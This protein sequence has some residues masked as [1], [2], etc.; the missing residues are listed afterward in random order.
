MRG[1]Y[2]NL[3]GLFQIFV[4]N[5]I[6]KSTSNIHIYKYGQT[7]MTIIFNKKGAVSK[8]PANI[9]WLLTRPLVIDRLSSEVGN[10][11]PQKL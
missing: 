7:K 1:K 6:S 10:D 11:N 5:V 3:F 2:N 8:A 9:T 4:E